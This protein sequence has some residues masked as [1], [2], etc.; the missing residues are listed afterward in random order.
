MILSLPLYLLRFHLIP[1]NHLISIQCN[2][3][4]MKREEGG[5]GERW[6]GTGRKGRRGGR[7][8]GD[9]Y[10]IDIDHMAILSNF[11]SIFN[12]VVLIFLL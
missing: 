10:I 2:S 5:E 4:K 1:L 6:R 11:K 3:Q 7:E 8:R 9:E 12:L